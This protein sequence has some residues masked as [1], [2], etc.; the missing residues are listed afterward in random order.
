MNK[1]KMINSTNAIEECYSIIRVT[2]ALSTS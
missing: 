2:H 1:D